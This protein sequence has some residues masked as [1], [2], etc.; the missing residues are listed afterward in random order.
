MN[1]K[2]TE[3]GTQPLFKKVIAAAMLVAMCGA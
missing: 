3:Q 2:Q 1:Q